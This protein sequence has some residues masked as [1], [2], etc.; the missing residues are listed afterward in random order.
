MKSEL[1]VSEEPSRSIR[2]SEEHGNHSAAEIAAESTK[3]ESV[4]EGQASLN[5]FG[6]FY[7]V[8]YHWILA[9]H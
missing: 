9:R 5:S 1:I 2:E 7:R 4:Q 3:E 6:P 8:I